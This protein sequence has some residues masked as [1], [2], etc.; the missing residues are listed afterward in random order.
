MQYLALSAFTL[1]PFTMG[2]APPP[3]IISTCPGIAETLVLSA[4][5]VSCEMFAKGMRNK[6]K[7]KKMIFKIEHTHLQLARTRCSSGVPWLTTQ[8]VRATARP[9][10]ITVAI[11]YWVQR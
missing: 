3:N 4:L 8:T 6:V 5:R 7:L 11:L 10:S 9:S 1:R 2:A